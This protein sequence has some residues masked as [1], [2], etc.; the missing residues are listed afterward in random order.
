MTYFTYL[1]RRNDSNEVFYIGKGCGRRIND[2]NNRNKHWNNIVAKHGFT[3]E[4]IAEWKEE[5]DAFLHE[6]FLIDCFRSMGCK[7]A[8]L[9]NGGEGG[10]YPKTESHR[11]NLSLAKKGVPNPKML[12]ELNP[13]KSKE[14]RKKRSIAMKKYYA[15]GGTNS[16]SGKKRPDLTIRNKNKENARYGVN[17]PKSR[18]ISVGDKTFESLMEA[19]NF[20]GINSGTLRYA[21]LTNPEKYNTAF[22]AAKV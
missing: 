4:K 19:A 20:L 3:Y 12:G 11:K 15:N 10:S 16:M 8:N 6:V 14:S 13:A 22:I 17:H 1:H 7:L 2:R 5:K 9:S 21:A 18:A